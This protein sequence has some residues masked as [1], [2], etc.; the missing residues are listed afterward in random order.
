MQV[1]PQVFWFKALHQTIFWSP[2]WGSDHVQEVMSLQDLPCGKSAMGD[3][4]MVQRLGRFLWEKG[5]VGGISANCTVNAAVSPFS[6][7]IP[8]KP[9][10]LSPAVS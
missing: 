2:S 8:H 3:A 7:P 1:I 4:Q 10:A 5:S 9:C 6:S